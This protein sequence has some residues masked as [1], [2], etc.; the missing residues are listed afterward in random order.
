M[1]SVSDVPKTL[2]RSIHT[3]GENKTETTSHDQKNTKVFIRTAWP[4]SAESSKTGGPARSAARTPK[5]CSQALAVCVNPN[6]NGRVVQK[7][8]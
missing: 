8:G 2:V 5:P 4:A 3:L 1:V 6:N 7:T